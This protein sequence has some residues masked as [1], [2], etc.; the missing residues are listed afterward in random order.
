[1]KIVLIIIVVAMTFTIDL[2]EGKPLGFTLR[3]A[4]LEV[5]KDIGREIWKLLPF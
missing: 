4:V 5:A 3:H 1:V 2:I